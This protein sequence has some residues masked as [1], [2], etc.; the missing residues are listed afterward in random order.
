MSN[1]PKVSVVGSGPVSLF[2]CWSLIR[3]NIP[4]EIISDRLLFNSNQYKLY[5]DNTYLPD[6]FTPKVIPSSQILKTNSNLYV[7]CSSPARSL[8]VAYFL[9]KHNSLSNVLIASSFNTTILDYLRQYPL[10][11]LYAWPLVSVEYDS[12]CLCSTNFLELSFYHSNLQSSA[13]TVASKIFNISTSMNLVANPKIFQARSILTFALYSFML[14]SDSLSELQNCS[15]ITNYCI[16]LVEDLSTKH[17][18]TVEDYPGF[19]KSL[20]L[21][22]QLNNLFS[23]IIQSCMESPASKHNLCFLFFNKSKLNRYLSEFAHNT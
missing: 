15:N 22:C 4:A 2:I 3:T 23:Q 7:L 9:H 8:E 10:R 20:P 21:D 11:S 13:L 14:N 17:G 5:I 16:P 12:Q 19:S 6:Y 18:L 1:T